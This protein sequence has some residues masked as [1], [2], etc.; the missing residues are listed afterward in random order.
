MLISLQGGV[1]RPDQVQRNFVLC[2]QQMDGNGEGDWRILAYIRC[3]RAKK[4]HKPSRVN[5]SL[6]VTNERG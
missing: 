2:C 4:S 6:T 3:K 5:K 1:V